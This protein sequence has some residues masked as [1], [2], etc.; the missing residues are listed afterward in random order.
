[1]T[2][3]A[4]GNILFEKI[5]PYF[6]AMVIGLVIGV[7]RE[8]QR[9][10]SVQAMGVRS[11]L[12]IS[13]LGAIAAGIDK[14]AIGLAI[15]LFAA[16]AILLGYFKTSKAA[17]ASG[18]PDIGMT[19]E[20]AAMAT[21][22]LGYL[23][24]FEPLLSLA[25]GVIMLS[26]LHHKTMLHSFIEKRITAHEIQ[27]AVILL[28]LSFGVIPLI[29]QGFVDP[30]NIFNLRR[31][32]I[33]ISVIAAIQFLGY[34]ASRIFGSRLGFSFAGLL[35]GLVSSTAVF[36]SHAELATTKPKFYLSTASAAMF[37]LVATLCQLIIVVA[38]MSWPLMIAIS[39]PVAIILTAAT[40]IAF[41][42]YAKAAP[43]S[44]PKI[45]HNPL[46]LWSAIKLGS[47]LSAII[48]VL[49]LTQRFLGELSAQIL[50]F[51]G[52][53]FELQGVVIARTNM[54]ENNSITLQAAAETVLIAIFASMVS[55]IGITAFLGRGSYRII[56]L[57]SICGLALLSAGSWLLVK[58]V[59]AVLISIF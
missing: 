2:I 59:P 38:V 42:F 50:T 30:W 16:A 25:L 14:A 7:E 46:N 31:L 54:F 22:G 39:I 12:L 41:S 32:A 49:E 36:I 23:A 21:F 6:I 35:G 56:V 26:A 10:N 55:K 37:S 17:L 57:S 3:F 47:L 48:I 24:H 5:S 40:A 28:L 51:L 4:V 52:G 34:V 1:M 53:L 8:R 9:L 33:I 13:L 58:W 43:G 45:Q 44:E 27:A 11:F 15:A 19:S 20:I 18:R 29:P